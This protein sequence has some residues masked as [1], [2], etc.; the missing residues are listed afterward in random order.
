[1][2]SIRCHQ[3]L[4]KQEEPGHAGTDS[5]EDDSSVSS[6]RV[7]SDCCPGRLT[8]AGFP[9]PI[10]LVQDFFGLILILVAHFEQR[11]RTGLFE[12][13][14]S[15]SLVPMYVRSQPH[16]GQVTRMLVNISTH[17]FIVSLDRPL[18]EC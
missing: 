9:R 6:Q 3:W 18:D 16:R 15:A 8:R 12:V 2:R 5:G 7:F 11:M 14:I 13:S 4:G 1:M 17:L 10:P